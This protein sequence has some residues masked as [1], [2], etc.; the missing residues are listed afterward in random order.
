MK[1]T[2][3]NIESII[4]NLPLDQNTKDKMVENSRI[5]TSFRD[6][7]C[8]C[9]GLT[10][11][12]AEKMIQNVT[13]SSFDGSVESINESLIKFARE[14]NFKDVDKIEKSLNYFKNV[15]R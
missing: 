4:E 9:D 3:D 1:V 14:K 7:L 10:K 6:H 2:F 11:E 8:D 15:K 13:T 12:A 5:I